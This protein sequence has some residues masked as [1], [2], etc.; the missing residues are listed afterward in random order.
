MS[1][2]SSPYADW[3]IDEFLAELRKTLLASKSFWL[4]FKEGVREVPSPDAYKRW[5]KTG[6]KTCTIEIHGIPSGQ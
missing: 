3:V 6:E 2:I 1:V 5:E 4:H